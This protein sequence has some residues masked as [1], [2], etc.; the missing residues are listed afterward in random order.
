MT[1]NIRHEPELQRFVS[2]TAAGSA[3]IHYRE[4]GGRVL[5]LDHTFVPVAVRGGG[6]A[7]QL[8]EH[9][10]RYARVHGFKVIASCPY[11]AAYIERHPGER[12]LL[13]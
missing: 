13:A 2:D 9:A 5:D 3:V 12:D 4:V 10:L 8:T 11:V 7:S 6:I 1:A